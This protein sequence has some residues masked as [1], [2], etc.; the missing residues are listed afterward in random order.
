MVHDP[1]LAPIRAR[2]K[3]RMA[4]PIR[5]LHRILIEHAPR[6]VFDPVL[7]IHRVRPHELQP[8]EAIVPVI[9]PC[10]RVDD[11]VLARRVVDELLRALVRREPV[12]ELPAIGRFLPRL[13][14][15]ADDLAV[16]EVAGDGPRVREL[17]DAQ[18][19][20]PGRVRRFPAA[21]DVVQARGVLEVGAVDGELVVGVQHALEAEAA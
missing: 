3:T 8:A 19:A 14:G 5:A 16:G 9:R 4:D 20:G 10:G 13:R 2:R 17:R 12:V 1:I 15:R 7:L 6:R 18:V 11:E 21:V